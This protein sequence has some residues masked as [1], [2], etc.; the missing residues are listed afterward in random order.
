MKYISRVQ[1]ICTS[2]PEDKTEK[3][4]QTPK[5]EGG[6][7]ESSRKKGKMLTSKEK[8]SKESTKN[9][10]GQNTKNNKRRNTKII[11]DKIQKLIKD[12][13]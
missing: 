5:T 13:M 12:K 9:N 10:R 4:S 8:K 3:E 2:G 6:T 11:K 1:Q 7:K